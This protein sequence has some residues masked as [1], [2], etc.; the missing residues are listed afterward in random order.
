MSIYLDENDEF[1]K[2]FGLTLNSELIEKENLIPLYVYVNK[3]LKFIKLVKNLHF[4]IYN[5]FSQTFSK[6]TGD[7]NQYIENWCLKENISYKEYEFLPEKLTNHI[8]YIL[9][10]LNN[11]KNIFFNEITLINL[12]LKIFQNEKLILKFKLDK[13]EKKKLK[14]LIQELNNLFQ[15]NKK[16]QKSITLGFLKNDFINDTKN[17]NHLDNLQKLLPSKLKFSYPQL[18]QYCNSDKFISIKM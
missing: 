2:L 13:K 8:K 3:K 5:I 7:T 14:F 18:F 11:K 16:I 12:E 9:Q 10:E 15:I 1:I 17:K 4:K 6:L